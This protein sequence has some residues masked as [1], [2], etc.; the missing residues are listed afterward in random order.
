MWFMNATTPQTVRRVRTQETYVASATSVLQT[1]MESTCENRHAH[2]S[3]GEG[4]SGSL[5]GSNAASNSARSQRFV[6]LDESLLIVGLS[7]SHN[8]VHLWRGHG[9]IR[10]RSHAVYGNE[11]HGGSRTPLHFT[12][13]P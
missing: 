6:E 1:Q 13:V 10:E 11:C 4:K 3:C 12:E 5:T 2:Q 8:H 7:P 9:G